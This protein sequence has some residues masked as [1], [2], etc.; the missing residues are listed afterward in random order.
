MF[1]KLLKQHIDEFYGF[2]YHTFLDGFAKKNGS[3]NI[4]HE[5]KGLCLLHTRFKHG[6]RQS[7]SFYPPDCATAMD[8]S[9]EI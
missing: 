8:F 3:K 1:A 9:D 5:W 4:S 7:L 2:G 6:S